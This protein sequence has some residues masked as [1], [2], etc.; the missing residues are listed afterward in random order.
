MNTNSNKFSHIL[1]NIGGRRDSRRTRS[2]RY[3]DGSRRS[4]RHRF[5]LDLVSPIERALMGTIG[6]PWA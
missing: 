3:A 1:V 4:E 5:E 2:N 6:R